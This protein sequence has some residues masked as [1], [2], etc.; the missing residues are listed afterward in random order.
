MVNCVSPA[1]APG[2]S[3]EVLETVGKVTAKSPL[4]DVN[5]QVDEVTFPVKVTLPSEAIA[6]H[7]AKPTTEATSIFEILF[8]FSSL[9]VIKSEPS[10]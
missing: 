5:S 2:V 6:A 1:V 8:N 7:D 3:K 4:V 9:K 10:N